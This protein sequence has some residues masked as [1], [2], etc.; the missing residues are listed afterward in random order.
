MKLEILI[1]SAVELDE[2]QYVKE[3][4][5]FMRDRLHQVDYDLY[6][7]AE[8][9]TFWATISKQDTINNKIPCVDWFICLIPEQTV[10]VG[11]WKELKLILEL[12]KAGTPVVISV[13]HPKECPKT[14]E[15]KT[16]GKQVDFNYILQEA[17]RILRSKEDLYW[18]SYK[19][20]DKTDLQTQLH[21]EFIKLYYTDKVFR[22][23]RL[24]ALAKLGGEIEPKELYFD[25][26]RADVKNGFKKNQ[27]FP[28][29]SVDGKL[30][31][32]IM[33]QRKFIILCGSPGSGKT[34]A[35]YQLMAPPPKPKQYALGT[36][37]GSNIII[38]NRDNVFQVY[39]FLACEAEYDSS[40]EALSKYYLVCDQL[41]D[42]FGML[43]N[44][45]LFKF[46]D[47]VMEF[48]HIHMIATSI[49]SAFDN[50]CERWKDY[51]YK[52]MEDD[53]L[54]KVITIPPISSDKEEG[55]MR[56]WMMNNLG[57]N[58]TAETIGD[59]IPQLNN[60]KQSIVQRLYKKIKEL[61]YLPKFLSALQI[62]E[63]FRHDTALFLPVLITSKNNSSENWE[64]IIKTINFL[65]ANNVIWVRSCKGHKAPMVVNQLHKKDFEL[66]H[67][68]DDRE[69]FTFD[70]ELFEKTPLSTSYSYGVNEIIWNWLE[71]EDASKRIA[72]NE[73]LLNDF[74]DASEVVRAAKEF[75]CAFP[76][77]KSLRRILPRIPRTECYDEASE[78]LWKFV[79]DEL[80]KISPQSSDVEVFQTTIGMLIGRSKNF[81]D[82]DKAIKIINEKK[83]K[84]NYSIIGELYSVGQRLG[85]GLKDD[86]TL[87]VDELRN[88]YRLNGDNC[89]SL[90]CKIDFLGTTFDD[91]L[92]SITDGADLEI[93]PHNLERLLARLANKAETPEQWNNLFKLYQK[94]DIKLRRSTIHLYFSAIADHCKR[95]RQGS[96]VKSPEKLMEE[97]LCTLIEEKQF[98]NIIAAE[99]KE[100]CYFYSIKASWNFTLSYSIYQLYLE[101]FKH[102]NPRLLSVV[103]MAVQKHEFQKALKFLIGVNEK[104]KKN[105]SELSEI[106]FNNLIKVA[107][108]IGEAL[109]VVSH[110]S[111]LQDYTL[112]NIL[113]SLDKRRVDDENS[114]TG[115]KQDP[116][117]FYYAYSAVMRESFAELRTSPYII[118][119]LYSLA[120]T[121]KHERF[122]RET[123]LQSSP[124]HSKY[125]LIDY[126]TTIAS[127]RLKRNY[128]TLDDVW[129]IF[130]TCRNYFLDN[131]LYIDSELY[132]SMMNKLKF[133]CESNPEELRK[134]QDRFRA[135]IKEDYDRIIRDEY[136]VPALYRFL[137]E[138]RMI[139]DRGNISEDFINEIR[140][141]KCT[142]IKPLNTI[143]S[144]LKCHGFD[145]V[146]EFYEFMNSYFR[147]NGRRK[148]LRPDTRTFTYLME[149]VETQEQFKKVVKTYQSWGLED[150]LYNNKV[151]RNVY[152]A[153]AKALGYNVQNAKEKKN[154]T[155]NQ[156]LPQ[157]PK[158]EE[159]V[160]KANYIIKQIENKLD[161]YDSLTPTLFN[162]N[163]KNI[164]D[165]IKDIDEDQNT[166]GDT[167]KT[168]L[169][170][171]IYTNI[172]NN[173]INKY[174]GRLFYDGLSYVY[175]I[176]LAPSDEIG[177][178][179]T[180]LKNNQ[181]I[182]KYDMVV[183]ATV[184][185]SDEVCNTDIDTALMYFRFW[186]D[187][188]RHIGYDPSD[189]E[190]IFSDPSDP[191]ST[192][193][194]AEII[195]GYW[196]TRCTHCIR[197]MDYYWK[198]SKDGSVDKQALLFIKEQMEF[199]ERHKIPFPKLPV[200]NG[201]VDFK[202]ELK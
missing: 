191:K 10:G 19:Y 198:H 71:K 97:S 195:K 82:V 193:A 180:K 110:M 69:E 141:L 26:N 67:D 106:C 148:E 121:P 37:S 59:Y 89:F 16:Q 5:E 190:S 172:Q 27:Y 196:F 120:T 186:E 65:I 72:Q 125:E 171:N 58:S 61:P 174:A 44:E 36:L 133:L 164:L 78:N 138:K 163:L 158:R 127:T 124:E 74:K 63:T 135:I 43:S 166:T 7:C 14:T 137:P 48:E 116:K 41:K 4:L 12:H 167:D 70:N 151:F 192:S 142:G 183:C 64:E 107:P 21:T 117:I 202:N 101:K 8:H 23:Q 144:D 109:A 62:T 179:I 73:T 197:E 159:Y 57:G 154:N 98:D 126:S 156:H 201:V 47:T 173:L 189:P 177:Q 30:Q 53:Q 75:Y 33:E 42:V 54:T 199:F 50:F 168:S 136:F 170:R 140:L 88:K 150:Q 99:D 60:Y 194:T 152:A 39:Q 128:R 162:Q 2:K 55:V 143:L 40:K 200:E 149:T 104:F 86:I 31:N 92:K 87:Y 108:N 76:S 66:D 112:A 165:I 49:P 3:R 34:R 139:D 122:I 18:V 115:Q 45:D 11:T 52:P 157:P 145:I 114:K 15:D 175:L 17:K 100:S 1:S 93:D 129:N 119:S 25:K 68:I 90:G 169:K 182:Y 32:A 130:N 178:W 9:G 38:V 29:R 51:G 6:D 123:F 160:Q 28:R 161:L 96:D 184:A 155:K 13:F 147:D 95:Q 188:V 24:K 84:P 80:K 111:H 91:A 181:E 85:K 79:Y 56:N 131:C 46:F 94:H 132:S 134:Q 187:I 35:L 22:T 185:Q 113:K 20:G 83:I 103:L 102:D 105:G 81:S 176:K 146:W 153:K 118:G 77:I